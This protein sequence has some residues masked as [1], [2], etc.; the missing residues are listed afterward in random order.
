MPGVDL[1]KSFAVAGV[2]RRLGVRF[3]IAWCGDGAT[4]SAV[5]WFDVTHPGWKL[6][7]GGAMGSS[8]QGSACA[9][10]SLPPTVSFDSSMCTVR[11]LAGTRR[12]DRSIMVPGALTV[13]RACRGRLSRY[14]TARRGC[15]WTFWHQTR[16]ARFNGAENNSGKSLTGLR[17]WWA[18]IHQ[19]RA[20]RDLASRFLTRVFRGE[21]ADGTDR[22]GQT[23]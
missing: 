3:G 11:Q 9:A 18:R 17:C 12:R 10:D 4:R 21:F 20:R 7:I 14:W 1:R 13:T 5:E 15:G 19:W 23:V 2:L 8:P 22:A 6:C 16:F